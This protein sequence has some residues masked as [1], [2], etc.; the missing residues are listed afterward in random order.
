[1]FFEPRSDKERIHNKSLIWARWSRL[2]P[3]VLMWL[4]A[5][6]EPKLGVALRPAGDEL[7]LFAILW[8]WHF[9]CFCPVFFFFAFESV[10]VQCHKSCCSEMGISAVTKGPAWSLNW[11]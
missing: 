4:G 11:T 2:T 1:M 3:A 9:W 6:S 7:S 10:F 5:A 8:G